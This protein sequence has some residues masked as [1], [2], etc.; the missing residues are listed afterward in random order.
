MLLRR[1]RRIA[2][3][4]FG[5][6]GYSPHQLTYATYDRLRSPRCYCWRPSVAIGN[7]LAHPDQPP[8]EAVAVL[9]DSVADEEPLVRKHAA[10]ALEWAGTR[11]G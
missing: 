6:P 7:W 3:P 9:R 10:W 4:N 5:Q 1:S 8:Q 11:L 2:A